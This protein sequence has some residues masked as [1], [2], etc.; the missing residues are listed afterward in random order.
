MT[1]D[2]RSDIVAQQY[3]RWLYP[4]PIPDLQAWTADNWEWF[5]PSHAHRIF[6]PDRSYKP[7]LDI[8]VAGCGTNQAAVFAL[9]NPKA[10]VVAIDVSR[11]SLENHRRL[12]DRHGL[13]NLDLRLLPIEEVHTL[14]GEFDLIV[15]S[16]VLHHLADPVRGLRSLAG[17]LKPHGVAAL[18]LYAR[19]GRIGV[20]MLQSVFRDLGLGQDESSVGLVRDA[21]EGLP[22]DHP[23]ASYLQIAPDLRYDAGLVDTFLHGRDR[24]YT[25]EECLGLVDSAGLAFQDLFF[26]A[27]YHP[28]PWAAGPF[29]SEVAAQVPTRQW[30][31]MERVQFNNGCH[32]FMACRPDRPKE[33]YQADFEAEG[34]SRWVP[35]LRHRCRLEEGRL[36]RSDWSIPLEPDHLAFVQRVD[37]SR[38]LAEIASEMPVIR[39]LPVQDAVAREL[40]AKTLFQVL[41][42]LDFLGVGLDRTD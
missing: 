8:L 30:S 37:G 23:V 21:L 42:R 31:I 28:P 1:D 26:K 27:P 41:W 2:P 19:Y 16:G 38:T 13:K 39:S 20:E 5:D 22:A 25:V 32:F 35:F 6:W 4:Q 3:E 15:S 11:P 29:F 17:C 9:N 7:D 12:R 40:F 34:A 36:H 33:T 24:S 18:M 10:S 14:G